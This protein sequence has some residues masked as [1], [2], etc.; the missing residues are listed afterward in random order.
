MSLCHIQFQSLSRAEAMDMAKRV[1]EEVDR[2]FQESFSTG[3]KEG[4]TEA[5]AHINGQLKKAGFNIE[6]TFNFDGEEQK[7]E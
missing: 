5:Y 3:K 7:D 4:V 1:Q 6:F 2:I